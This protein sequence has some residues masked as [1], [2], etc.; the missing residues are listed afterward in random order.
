M[1]KEELPTYA[2]NLGINSGASDVV[3]SLVSWDGVMIRFSNNEVTVSKFFHE[4]VMKIF[5]MVEKHR[6]ASTINVLSKEAVEDTVENLIKIAKITPPADIY[7]PLPK[8]P[9][10]YDP[11]LLKPSNVLQEPS[12]LTEYVKEGIDGALEAGAQRVAGSLVAANTQVILETS[13]N[14]HAEQKSSSLEISIRA[15]TSKFSSGHGVSISQDEK[16]FQ[17]FEAGKHAGE[18]AKLAQNPKQI[19]PG[20]YKALLGPLIFANFVNQIGIQSSAFLIDAGQSFLTGKIGQ[21]VAT[22]LFTL[23]DDPTIPNTYG[24]K[25]FDDE[26]VP[27][28]N[29]V[30][31][32]RGTLKTYL[33]NTTTSKKFNTQTTSNAGLIVP[34]PWNLV[35]EQ[36]NKRFEDLL[37]EIDHGI[38]VTNGWYLR[39]QDYQRGDFSIV[40]RDGIFLIKDRSIAH[41]VKDLRISDN[42]LRIFQNIEGISSERLWVKW[43]EVEVPTLTPYVIVNDLNFTR[44]LF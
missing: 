2:V 15:F 4:A 34:Q 39:F 31:V 41:P 42:M 32:E 10:I 38:Y 40:P 33:H 18:I 1:K 5:I 8:G 12:K 19:E 30:I 28:R 23:R 29:N 43:W 35:V 14:V 17:P 36:G 3:A 24:T 16:G 22:E 7:A 9:F 6:A 25:A 20:K 37:S 44:S 21:K 13:G 26:G 11:S 27:T